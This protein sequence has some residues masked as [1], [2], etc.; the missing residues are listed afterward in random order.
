MYRDYSKVTK[1]VQSFQAFYDKGESIR[2]GIIFFRFRGYP[3]IT[4]VSEG[5]GGVKQILTF[6]NKVGGGSVKC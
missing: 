1:V 4:L 6:A 2:W 5:G 3:L